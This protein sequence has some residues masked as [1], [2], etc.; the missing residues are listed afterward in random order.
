MARGMTMPEPVPPEVVETM[1]TRMACLSSLPVLRNRSSM[2]SYSSL[3]RP[4]LMVEF[5]ASREMARTWPAP[6]ETVLS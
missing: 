1:T 2:A 4:V 5:S 3:I 6:S